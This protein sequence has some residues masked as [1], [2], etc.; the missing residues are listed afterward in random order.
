M[1]VTVSVDVTKVGEEMGGCTVELKL[2]GEVV[3]SKEIPPFGGVYPDFD[4]VTATVSFEVRTG[5]FPTP[6]GDIE[7]RE[8][9]YQVE[10]EGLTGSFTVKPESSYWS[11]IP[12]FPY[13][14]ILS[15]LVFGL[16]AICFL[17]RIHDSMAVTMSYTIAQED[18]RRVGEKDQRGK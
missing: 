12:G 16:L 11:N 8:G 5:V 18:K 13:E 7:R 17:Y 6:Q 15:G 2:N 14:S 4:R 1:S 3:D 10:V 9:T